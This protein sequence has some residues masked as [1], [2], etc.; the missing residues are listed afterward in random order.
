MLCA[1]SMG[2]ID[3]FDDGTARPD[4]EVTYVQFLTMTVRALGYG[5]YAD[6]EGGYPL[7]YC[8]RAKTLKLTAEIA[9][10][11]LTE[12]L[13]RDEAA[14]VLYNALDVPLVAVCGYRF[15]NG[16]LVPEYTVCDGTGEEPRQTLLT[17]LTKKDDGR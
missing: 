1:D 9:E 8:N 17:N 5:M 10:K 4:D 11:E 2:I 12:P 15:D 3:G 6:D 13:A 16:E 14:Q 7:G